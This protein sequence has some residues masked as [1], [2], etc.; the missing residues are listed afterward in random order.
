MRRKGIVP[1]GGRHG[2]AVGAIHHGLA[3]AALAAGTHG[4]GGRFVDGGFVVSL[5]H[6]HGLVE[7]A[8]HPIEAELILHHGVGG[9]GHALGGPVDV[10]GRGRVVPKAL[11]GAT[12]MQLGR[13]DGASVAHEHLAHARVETP[14]HGRCAQATREI[15][16]QSVGFQLGETVD[17]RV[18]NPVAAIVQIR[19]DGGGAQTGMV[20]MARV[21][22]GL[23]RIRSIG[24]SQGGAIDVTDGIGAGPH[25]GGVVDDGVLA[26]A[27][28]ASARGP[29][30]LSPAIARARG[31]SGGHV[32][33][34]LVSQEQVPTSETAG[35]V[36]T[37]ERL[38]FG[39]GA[40][41]TFEMFQPSERA[42][43]GGAAMGPRLVGLGR[44]D[45]GL[46]IGLDLFRF[47]G[48]NWGEG[49]EDRVS[50]HDR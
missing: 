24:E 34:L 41:M 29:R 12:K 25:G 9:R 22:G 15:H 49:K 4:R 39:V 37:L 20:G 18:T 27:V 45:I 1:A 44:R 33:F 48:W 13:V 11:W 30:A 28:G 14:I 36:R 47:F 31:W 32:E 2:V 46:T 38:L 3:D 26:H 40:L 19:A 10:G 42:T 50:G 6:V 43:A 17:R 7:P 16:G 5:A 21:M 35:T 8:I 23:W